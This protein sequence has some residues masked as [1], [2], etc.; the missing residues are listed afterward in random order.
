SLNLNVRNPCHRCDKGQ[1]G[2]WM[3]LAAMS[4]KS[5]MSRCGQL[6]NPPPSGVAP[7]TQTTAAA[8]TAASQPHYVG[9]IDS[10]RRPGITDMDPIRSDGNLYVVTG[11]P[12]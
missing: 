2:G 8:V 7:R 12:L 11:G 10:S 1:T 3:S 9:T 4:R 5:F 6:S